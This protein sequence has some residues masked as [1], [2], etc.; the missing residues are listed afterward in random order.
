[1]AHL[2]SKLKQC[3]DWPNVQ[4]V[5]IYFVCSWSFCSISDVCAFFEK[6]HGG[7]KCFSIHLGPCM[8]ITP[9]LLCSGPLPH[10]HVSA[11]LPYCRLVIT[12]FFNGTVHECTVSSMIHVDIHFRYCFSRVRC[13]MYGI[14]LQVVACI[15]IFAVIFISIVCPFW[16]KYLQRYKAIIHGGWDEAIPG[17]PLRHH[18]SD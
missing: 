6:K 16:L 13:V 1:M 5:R 11:E 9:A 4:G 12:F 10:A 8:L 15:Y 3:T 14:Y 7:V 17:V 2:W 18:C